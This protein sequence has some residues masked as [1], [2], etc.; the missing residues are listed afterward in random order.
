MPWEVEG[1]RWWV[2]LKYS[3]SK[4]LPESLNYGKLFGQ[5]SPLPLSLL[6]GGAFFLSPSSYWCCSAGLFLPGPGTW[7]GESAR[8]RTT[9]PHAQSLAVSWQSHLG[10]SWINRWFANC[11][12]TDGTCLS[13]AAAP[14]SPIQGFEYLRQNCSSIKLENKTSVWGRQFPLDFLPEA[15]Q[16]GDL[17]CWWAVAWE[18]ENL[19]AFRGPTLPEGTLRNCY[20]PTHISPCGLW[21]PQRG[22]TWSP[23]CG[24]LGCL[25][26]P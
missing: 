13:I 22:S 4:S 21:V 17:G 7:L 11:Q 25:F 15:I 5:K 1:G 18:Q 8:S 10:L 6:P 19:L 14:S 12:A 26:L 24:G 23:R 3:F 20:L 9:S 16:I 2:Y